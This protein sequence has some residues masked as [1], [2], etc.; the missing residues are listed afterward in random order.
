MLGAVSS[1]PCR[2]R[3]R[4][5]RGRE[6]SNREGWAHREDGSEWCHFRNSKEEA[7]KVVEGPGQQGLWPGHEHDVLWANV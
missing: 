4:V 5:S 3:D 6:T 7:E 2:P 1:W